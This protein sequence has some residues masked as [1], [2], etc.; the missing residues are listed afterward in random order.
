[1]LIKPMLAKNINFDK[2]VFPSYGLLALPKIDGSFAFNQNA[3]L[4]ARSL[5]QHENEYVTKQFSKDKYEGLRGEMILGD[6][7]VAEGLCRATSS[8]LRTVKGEPFTTLHCFDYVTPKTKEVAYEE[9]YNMLKNTVSNLGVI[10]IRVIPAVRVFSLE[11]FYSLRDN[12]ISQGYEGIIL[13]DPLAK[14]KEGRSS[15]IKP[16]L[17][18]WKPWLSAEILVTSIEEG[19]T[20]LNEA[21]INELG[22][23]DRSSHKENKAPNG[24]LGRIRGKLLADLLDISGKVIQNAG[25]EIVVSPGDMKHYERKF[26][27]SNPKEIVG[28]I[29]EFDYFAYGMKQTVRMPQFKRIRSERDM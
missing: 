27:L 2:L 21:R 25:E 7:P 20:N 22:Y 28:H 23:T 26:Y 4:Y 17:W 11:E 13:R 1:M 3:T 10:S 24:M 29:V 14:H 12:F 6:N 19:E 8:A 18:R 5:K 9:R 16:E 15:S